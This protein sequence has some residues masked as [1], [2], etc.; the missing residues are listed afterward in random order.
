MDSAGAA[1][2]EIAAF[3][4]ARQLQ[5]LAQQIEQ[6][7]AR[8]NWDLVA[9]AIDAQRDRQ[10]RTKFHVLTPQRLAIFSAN[11]SARVLFV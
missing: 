7:G 8:I 2:T 10:M 9:A 11:R 6:C 5:V 1:F 4:G 3:L